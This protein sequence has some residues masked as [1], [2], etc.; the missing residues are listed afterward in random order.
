MMFRVG[1]NVLT[2]NKA[3]VN[4]LR[5]GCQEQLPFHQGKVHPNADPRT[6]AERQECASWETLFAFWGETLWIEDIGVRKGIRTPVQRIGRDKHK[7]F[8]A[9]LIPMDIEIVQSLA[10]NHKGRRIEA[11]TFFKNVQAVRETW[12][13]LKGGCPTSQNAVY[14]RLQAGID[15]GMETEQIPAPG[16]RSGRRLVACDK[17]D[18]AFGHDLLITH[19]LSVLGVCLEE[20]REE[21]VT[22]L[23][24][25]AT[26]ID[27]SLKHLSKS[28]NSPVCTAMEWRRPAIGHR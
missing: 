14:L 8:P 9:Y 2:R 13:I 7:A 16:Q 4:A 5:Q 24:R 11:Q 15:S 1:Q 26:L 10:Q 28:G 22:P 6:Y 25:K 23:T 3:K 20:E 21:I 12:E 17:K 19:G 27:Q 18:L